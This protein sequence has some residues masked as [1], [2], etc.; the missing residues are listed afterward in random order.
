V[1]CRGLAY[2]GTW[3]PHLAAEFGRGVFG[4]GWVRGVGCV[5]E[6]LRESTSI[7]QVCHC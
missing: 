6:G 5:R 7:L 2:V 1:G 3:K 4:A